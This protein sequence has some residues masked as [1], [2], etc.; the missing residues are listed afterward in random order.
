MLGCSSSWTGTRN[1]NWV[2][3]GRR[4]HPL[5]RSE[6]ICNMH[7]VITILPFRFSVAKLTMCNNPEHEY[8]N[9]FCSVLFCSV[10]FCS[11]SHL[12]I[13][14]GVLHHFSRN[15]GWKFNNKT[16]YKRPYF[17]VFPFFLSRS[18][19]YPSIRLFSRHSNFHLLLLKAILS[20]LSQLLSCRSVLIS[21]VPRFLLSFLSFLQYLFVIPS[22][23]VS[24]SPFLFNSKCQPLTY[25]SSG[26]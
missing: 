4:H 18:F 5:S 1:R 21:F 17:Y 6:H 14:F 13:S 16:S 12:Y 8:G 15:S 22:F 25:N 10:L 9:L 23:S 2:A 3:R 20:K 7:S 26:K 19:S 24:K 11:P